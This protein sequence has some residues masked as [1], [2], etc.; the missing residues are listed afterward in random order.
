MGDATTTRSPSTPAEEAASAR[1]HSER[2][3]SSPGSTSVSPAKTLEVP[4]FSLTLRRADNVPL[5]LN[6]RG[7][8]GDR[9][10]TIEAVRPGGAVEAWNRQCSGES[11]SI[12]PGDKVVAINNAED[13]ASMRV[14]CLNKRLLKMTVQRGAGDEPACNLW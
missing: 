5:G 11:R 4:T 10:L 12:R 2:A 7:Q 14:E 13:A 8:E 9:R 3:D 1:N 6:V